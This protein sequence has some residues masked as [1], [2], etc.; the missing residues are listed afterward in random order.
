[1]GANLRANTVLTPE[2]RYEF[3]RLGEAVVVHRLTKFES[4]AIREAAFEWL[5]EQQQQRERLHHE[6]QRNEHARERRWIIIAATVIGCIH[7]MAG[8]AIAWH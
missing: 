6:R 8:I 2:L 4:R 3:S 1:M 5:R 7:I